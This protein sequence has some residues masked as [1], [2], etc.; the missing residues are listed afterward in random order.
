MRPTMRL[1]SG[2]LRWRLQSAVRRILGERGYGSLQERWLA[3]SIRSPRTPEPEAEVLPYVVEEGGAAVDAGANFGFY[4]FR[5]AKLVGPRGRVVSIEPIPATRAMLHRLIE[6]LGIA[7]VVQ[8]HGTG[9]SDREGTA[10]FQV[11]TRA[12]GSLAGAR[13]WSRH[14]SVAADATTGIEVPMARLDD[15]IEGEVQFMKLDVEGAEL[16]ALRGATRLLT[17]S[18]PTLLLEVSRS[19]LAR[20]EVSREELEELLGDHGYETYAYDAGAKRLM[21]TRVATFDGNLIAVHPRRRSAVE[22]LL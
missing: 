16:F 2:P 7:D 18:A 12:D 22:P 4:T 15:L 17:E 10:V 6:R 5:L 1:P 8:V 9:A 21:P 14:P 20:Q 11:G 13:A 3:Y 19:T